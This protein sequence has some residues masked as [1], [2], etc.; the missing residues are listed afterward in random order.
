LPS[1]P[2]VGE[3]KAVSVASALAISAIAAGIL[4]LLARR[5]ISACWRTRAMA[6]WIPADT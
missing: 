6:F 3:D 4:N 5:S 2:V 1:E